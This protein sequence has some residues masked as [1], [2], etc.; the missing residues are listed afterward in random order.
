[1]LQ[2]REERRNLA[3]VVAGGGSSGGGEAAAAT[4]VTVWLAVKTGQRE[5]QRW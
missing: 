1:L 3:R 2:I 4:P 5:K